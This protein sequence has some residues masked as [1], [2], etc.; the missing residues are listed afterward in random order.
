MVNQPIESGKYMD[1]FNEIKDKLN[2]H[3]ADIN[4][5]KIDMALNT[6]LTR[7]AVSSGEELNK[8]MRSFEITM[9]Q[10]SNHLAKSDE[11]DEEMKKS[12]DKIDS[13][14]EKLNNKVEMIEDKGQFDIMEWIKKNFITLAI[15][16]TLA[17]LYIS[18]LV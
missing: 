18:K 6:D 16:V 4:Q 10:I 1:E 17:G 8:T 12:I 2:K 14:V 15:I 9:V 5:L 11:R 3:D 13:K 7:R